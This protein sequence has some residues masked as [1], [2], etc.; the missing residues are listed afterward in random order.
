MTKSEVRR[1]YGAPVEV[2]STPQGEVWFY[3]A[4][5]SGRD[6]IPIYGAVT[7]RRNGGSIGFDSHGRVS[8]FQWGRDY[9]NAWWY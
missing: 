7:H 8:A 9:R 2:S 6:F 1:R 3:T 5:V 4:R